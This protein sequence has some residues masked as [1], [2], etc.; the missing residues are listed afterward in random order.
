MVDPPV[1]DEEGV[2][3][4]KVIYDVHV[5]TVHTEWVMAI[6]GKTQQDRQLQALAEIVSR[7][8]PRYLKEVPILVKPFWEVK[9]T[10]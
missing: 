8:W 3:D 6:R 10:L 9:D 2:Q 1:S 4:E 7:G 5:V